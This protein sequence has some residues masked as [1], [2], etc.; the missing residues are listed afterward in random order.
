MV[1][2]A[3]GHADRIEVLA[4]RDGVLAGHAPEVS[5]LGNG[6]G[7]FRTQVPDRLLS[8]LIDGGGVTAPD[9]RIYDPQGKWVVEN[10][11]IEPDIVVDLHPAEVARG[12]DAQLMTAIN[13]LLEKIEKEPRPWPEHEPFPV[14]R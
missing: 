4:K 8:Q 14:D 9:Y 12:Y 1:L 6:C 11:G 7:P 5:Q 2:T 10:V 3:D 13:Y